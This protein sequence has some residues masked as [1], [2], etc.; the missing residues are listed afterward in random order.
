M[1][2]EPYVERIDIIEG[3]TLEHLM[4]AYELRPVHAGQPAKMCA[5]FDHVVFI[6]KNN[7]VQKELGNQLQTNIVDVRDDPAS[8]NPDDVIVRISWWGDY[9][10]RYNTRTRKGSLMLK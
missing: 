6:G 5:K 9:E 2:A 7:E 1:A 3:P 8:T 4:K 10:G